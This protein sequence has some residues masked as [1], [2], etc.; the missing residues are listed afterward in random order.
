MKTF[1]IYACVLAMLALNACAGTADV[2]AQPTG[3]LRMALEGQGPDGVVYRLR[4]ALF[5]ITGPS[6][7]SLDSEV[8]PAADILSTDVPAG[9]YQVALADGWYMER[10]ANGQV[11]AVNAV[12]QSVN[13]QHT[14]LASQATSD[15]VFVFAVNN[16]PVTFAPGKLNVAIEV[17]ECDGT[18]GEWAGCRGNGCAVCAEQLVDY[19]LYLANH[20]RCTLN[21]TCDGEFFTCNARCPAPTDADREPAQCN[22]TP[23]EWAGCRGNGCAVCAEQLRGYT[24]YT[25]NHPRCV[26]NETCDGQFYT[27]NADCPAPTMADL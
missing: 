14:S 5:D 26:V 2:D 22:G 7:I 3:S 16:L 10:E 21:E 11:V 8:D 12:L 17:V 13:P 27:C 19:P 18:P 24:R 25:Q 20:P 6:Q 1:T 15:V 9:D 4:S 23:G